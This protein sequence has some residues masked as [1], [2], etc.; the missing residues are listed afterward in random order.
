M[1]Q[2]L[3]VCL[4]T[5]SLREGGILEPVIHAI[6]NSLKLGRHTLLHATIV[7]YFHAFTILS[8]LCINTSA[9]PQHNASDSRSLL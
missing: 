7:V 1:Q 4:T 8:L 2:A 9:N 6:T 3:L 5:L